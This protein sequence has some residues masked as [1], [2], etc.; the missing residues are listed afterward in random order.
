MTSRI[1]PHT[2]GKAIG[3]SFSYQPLDKAK[4]FYLVQFF[5]AN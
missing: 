1:S 3:K 4:L 2:P 5:G